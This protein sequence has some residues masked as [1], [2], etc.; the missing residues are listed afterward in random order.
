MV[1]RSERFRFALK[2]SE[3]IVIRRQGPRQ[4]LDGDVAI[5]PRVPRPIDLAHAAGPEGGKN[6]VRAEADA[7]L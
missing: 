7:G 5:E 1:Q 6:L 2:A 4:N 3:S